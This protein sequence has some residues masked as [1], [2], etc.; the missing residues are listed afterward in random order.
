MTEPF[1][2]YLEWDPRWCK[3]PEELLSPCPKGHVNRG[4]T[5]GAKLY[6]KTC[7]QD[8]IAKRKRSR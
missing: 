7:D 6:C 4:V 5:E 8:R 2:G 3:G 1:S